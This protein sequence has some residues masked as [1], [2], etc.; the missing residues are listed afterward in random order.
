MDLPP[1]IATVHLSGSPSKESDRFNAPSDVVFSDDGSVFVAD[2]HA[3]TTNNRVVKFAPDGSYIQRVGGNRLAKR[4]HSL[5]VGY[6]RS[7]IGS[8][9]EF[10]AVDGEGNA[11]GNK[12]AP[13][14]L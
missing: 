8:G 4:I 7:T 6:P 11:Y 9:A 3:N 12:P 14:N 2:G 1:I 5:P 10:V 13:Q